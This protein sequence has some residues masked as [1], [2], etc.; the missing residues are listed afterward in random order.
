MEDDSENYSDYV[1]FSYNWQNLTSVLRWNHIFTPT[2][3]ANFSAYNSRFKQE[4]LNQFDKK[5][6]EYYKGFNN[7]NDWSVKGD[8]DWFP[9][10]SAEFKF[11]YKLSSQKFSPEIISYKSDL[12]S[13]ELN[14]DVFTRN[15]ISEIYMESEISFS[16]KLR[17]NIGLRGGI[18]S[19]QGK[20]YPS[21]RPRISLRYLIADNVSG[22]ISYSRMKQFLH[23]LQN[24]TL[25]IPTEL[26][27]SST[28]KIKPGT[29]DLF[30]VGVFWNPGHQYNFSAEVYYSELYNVI[31]YKEGALALKERNDSWE[32]F[33]TT[34]KGIAYGLE[35]MAEKTIGDLTGWIAYTLS[36]S[37]GQF[38]EINFGKPFPYAYDRRHQININ[39]NYFIGEKI[40]KGKTIKKSISANFNFAT[41]KY[42]TLAEQEYQGIPLPLMEGSRYNADWFARRSLLN[43]VNN[44]QMPDFH[45]L[46]LSY[47]IERESTDKTIIWNFSVYNAYN[48]LN[49]WYYYTIVR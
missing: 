14:K 48:R 33:V 25:G 24:T 16:E 36:K 4:Y 5:G 32:D 37:T 38:D 46:N 1:K 41:G 2:L 22:K 44:Y 10:S 13:F 40:K 49:P 12:S 45:H 28:D 9:E 7:L 19:T 3:F 42:I 47:R 29:S 6:K 27:V 8:F 26:W 18:M 34:G 20:I 21:L 23:Q 39:A 31:R 30:S 11:G 35:L 17:G 15:I 43:S